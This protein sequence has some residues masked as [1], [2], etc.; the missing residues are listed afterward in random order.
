MPGTPGPHAEPSSLTTPESAL[1]PQHG[2]G[3]KTKDTRPGGGMSGREDCGWGSR[4][5][6]LPATR[7]LVFSAVA[8]RRGP[9][10][11]HPSH[12]LRAG[13]ASQQ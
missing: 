9:V 5:P 8:R 2:P 11:P 6:G 7:R 13:R 3:A 1:S 12:L 4:N 10:L